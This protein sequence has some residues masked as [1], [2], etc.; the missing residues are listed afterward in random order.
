[1]CDIK[2]FYLELFSSP[3]YQFIDELSETVQERKKLLGSFYTDQ[4]VAT[5]LVRR[6]LVLA[7]ESLLY[8]SKI[9]IIDPFCGDGRL[10]ET[11]LRELDSLKKLKG[12]EIDITLWDVDDDAL[13]KSEDKINSVKAELGF[14]GNVTIENTDSF[15]S[16]IDQI[17]LYDFCIT[18]PPWGLL[19]PLKIINNR[20]DDDIIDSYKNALS[21]YD[22]YFKSEFA[23]SQPNRKFGKWGTNLGRAGVEVATCLIKNEGVCGFVSPASLFNDQVSLN[24][25][26]VLF[27]NYNIES[28]SY[29]PAKLKLYGTADV[30]SV[31]VVLT[32]G[33]TEGISICIYNEEF[34][35]ESNYLDVSDLIRVRENGYRIGLENGIELLK[36]DHLFNNLKSMKEICE[37]HGLIFTR[38]LDETR[39]S[40]KF[41]NKS[42]YKFAKGYMVDRYR[43]DNTDIYLD[44]DKIK[45]PK[46]AEFYKLVWRD[47][48]RSTQSRR[49]KSTIIEPGFIAGNSLGIIYSNSNDLNKLK[50]LVAIFNSIIFE[51]QTKNKLVSNHVPVGV[52]KTIKIPDLVDN[53]TIVSLVDKRLSGDD[54]D[55]ELEVLIA[56]LY[57]L[58]KNTFISIAQSFNYDNSEIEALSNFWERYKNDF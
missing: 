52:I 41:A 11:F 42:Q 21:A 58:D 37:Q 45:I 23:T 1:M 24:F 39:I 46:S 8:N 32:K 30:S 29:F 7:P 38:E 28:I 35:K 19:K 47:V 48:S 57:N 14:V 16:Y 9:S 56:K 36:F 10:I 17:G 33:M 44:V 26:R 40:E 20:I 15:V 55:L 50:L 12:R 43:F 22:D 6:I 4:K 3:Y 5:E 51:F 53:Q 34:A 54:V 27:D 18:N 49:V 2:D 31:T 13:L 25:R